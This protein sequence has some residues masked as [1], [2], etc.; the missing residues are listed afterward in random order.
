MNKTSHIRRPKIP[1][2]H[3]LES[4]KDKSIYYYD[5]E[6]QSS[7]RESELEENVENAQTITQP[8]RFS[9][10]NELNEQLRLYLY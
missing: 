1:L 4:L 6:N 8:Y 7:E 3:S 2:S 5:L 9:Q 10:N